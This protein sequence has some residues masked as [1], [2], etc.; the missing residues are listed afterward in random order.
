MIDA[1]KL[2]K[3]LLSL[4]NSPELSDQRIVRMKNLICYLSE[5]RKN[6][7]VSSNDLPHL[8]AVL[9][10]ASVKLRTFGYNRQNNLSAAEIEKN[11]TP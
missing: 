4:T 10:A 11:F 9:Y 3:E 8:E 5:I 7:K 6:G 2:T 1:K